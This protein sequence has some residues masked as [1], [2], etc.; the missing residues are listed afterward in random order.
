MGTLY[1]KVERK[2]FLSAQERLVV[3][4]IVEKHTTNGEL[5]S[6]VLDGSGEIFSFEEANS[7]PGII[8]EG[9]TQLPMGLFPDD[10]DDFILVVENWFDLLSEVR[11]RITADKWSVV[12]G[13]KRLHWNEGNN[14]Y[15]KPK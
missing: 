10:I 2:D 12:M 5:T 1:Y 4:E 9:S 8:L 6:L 7:A 3:A 15:E 11:N 14:K 13:D